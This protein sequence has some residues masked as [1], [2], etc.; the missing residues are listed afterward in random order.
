MRR[1]IRA[2]YAAS[3]LRKSGTFPCTY[4]HWC[5][6]LVC[7]FHTEQRG[8][9]TALHSR[10]E[11]AVVANECRG[12]MSVFFSVGSA[13]PCILK[14]WAVR[15]WV[16]KA[17]RPHTASVLCLLPLLCLFRVKSR[18][19]MSPV[20]FF[21]FCIRVCLF[22]QTVCLTPSLSASSAPPSSGLALPAQNPAAAS[23]VVLWE[24]YVRTHTFIHRAGLIDFSLP[25]EV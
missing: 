1:D 8:R 14:L 20:L 16:R 25:V 2:E 17:L 22:A 13:K 23:L 21:F 24:C 4:T 11:Q 3:V 5:L 19:L 18:T 10:S 7:T 9:M 15:R 12:K 6:I